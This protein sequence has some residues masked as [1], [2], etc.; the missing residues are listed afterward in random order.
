MFG[1]E[2]SEGS[3]CLRSK[4]DPKMINPERCPRQRLPQERLESLKAGLT[5]T[6]S[7][8]VA[9]VPISFSAELPI[10]TSR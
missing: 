2:I 5:A 6:A 3:H 7:G 1:G 4:D 9:M 10:F 8:A